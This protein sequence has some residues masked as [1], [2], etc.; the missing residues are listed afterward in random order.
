MY[1]NMQASTK[2]MRQQAQQ[3]EFPLAGCASPWL[4]AGEWCVV[5]AGLTHKQNG[6]KVG[7]EENN[8]LPNLYPSTP[9]ITTEL[10]CRENAHMEHGCKCHI[11]KWVPHTCFK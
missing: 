9:H 5:G 11:F 2:H 7:R 3:R 1:P 8:P 10:L 4:P 6:S